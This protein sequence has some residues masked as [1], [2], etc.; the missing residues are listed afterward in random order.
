MEHPKLIQGDTK[1]TDADTKG[2][3]ADTKGTDADTKG[4]DA[5]T[6]GTDAKVRRALMQTALMQRRAKGTDA[7]REE[8]RALM[9]CERN[10]GH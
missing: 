9:H 1:G 10:E 3:D 8:R 7:L 6:K 2:T 5:D 4:T